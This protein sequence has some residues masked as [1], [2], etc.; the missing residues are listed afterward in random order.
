MVDPV[1]TLVDKSGLDSLESMTIDM[2]DQ[3]MWIQP[4]FGA[5]CPG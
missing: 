4:A 1:A 5:G 2:R 3:G